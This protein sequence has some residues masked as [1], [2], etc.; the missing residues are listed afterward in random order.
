MNDGFKS[1]WYLLSFVFL[2]HVGGRGEPSAFSRG[3]AA[4]CTKGQGS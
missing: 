1:T 3:S 4:M 2:K